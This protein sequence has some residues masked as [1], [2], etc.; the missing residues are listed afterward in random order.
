MHTITPLIGIKKLAAYGAL[1][2][3]THSITA[4]RGN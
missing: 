4:H 3:T 1:V 2:G